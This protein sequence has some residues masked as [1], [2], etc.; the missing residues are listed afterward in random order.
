MQ[1]I[2]QEPSPLQVPR[3]QTKTAPRP[4]SPANRRSGL[5][6]VSENDN[7]DSDGLGAQLEF[8]GTIAAAC[9]LAIP[10]DKFIN[11]VRVAATED[12]GAAQFLA[13]W[14]ILS[15]AERKASGAADAVCTRL[16]ISSLELLGVVASAACRFSMYLA[17]IAAAM[18]MPSVV[19]QS[20]KTALTD[21][22]IADRKML[23]QHSG[24]LP[25]P[26][27]SQTAVAIMQNSQ[28]SRAAGGVPA[29]IPEQTIRKAMAVLHE[30][31]GLPTVTAITVPG[32]TSGSLP[33]PIPDEGVE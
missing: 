8:T 27:R 10:L 11:M 20:V 28:A 9:E 7:P 3:H 19:V 17:Q 1:G 32:T 24:F 25:T 30:S 15:D 2:T 12:P 21:D 16:Q 26:G 22:G 4:T 5:S 13:A 14:D 18:A 33:D 31:R 6:I 23:F 29:P